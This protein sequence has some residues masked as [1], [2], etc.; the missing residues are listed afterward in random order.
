MTVKLR[1]RQLI[2]VLHDGAG[3][4]FFRETAPYVTCQMAE[5]AVPREVFR[6]ILERLNG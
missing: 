3:W 1:Y 5:V 4:S 6:A 2:T